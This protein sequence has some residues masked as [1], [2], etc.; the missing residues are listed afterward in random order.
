[1]VGLAKVRCAPRGWICHAG[2]AALFPLPL[3]GGTRPVCKAWHHNFSG[4]TV[5]CWRFTPAPFAVVRV[6][7]FWVVRKVLLTVLTGAPLGLF[8]PG[9]L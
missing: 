3:A 9:W 6:L 2:D 5:R 7:V 8:S 4:V 1:M